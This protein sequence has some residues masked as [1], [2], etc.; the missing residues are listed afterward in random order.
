MAGWLNLDHRHNFCE[1]ITSFITEF[2]LLLTVANTNTKA[3]AELV[4]NKKA[5]QDNTV[6]YARN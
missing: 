3:L 5:D 4:P 2:L 6:R 1:L